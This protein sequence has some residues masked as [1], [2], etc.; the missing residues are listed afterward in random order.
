MQTSSLRSQARRRAQI[1]RFGVASGGHLC[2]QV[3]EQIS[4]SGAWG[5]LSTH[6]L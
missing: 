1:T 4:G 6:V 3:A 2:N 5:R